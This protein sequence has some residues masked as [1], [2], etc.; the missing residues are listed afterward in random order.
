M[1][2]FDQIRIAAI[3]AHPDDE[4]FTTGGVLAAF[5]DRGS[6]VTLICAT[7]GEEGEISHPSLATPDNLGEVREQELRDAAAILG[8][9]DVRF[10]DYRD[11]G[12]HGTESNQA[13]EAFVRQP[14][15]QVV[16]KLADILREIR[17]DLVITFSEEGVYFHPD[18]IY[19]HQVVLELARRSPELVPELYFVSF[20]RE[21][22][23][24][25]ANQDHGAFS[26]MPAEQR[27]RLGQPRDSFT[28]VVDVHPYVDRKVDA[29]A[30]HKTQQAK[31]GDPELFEDQEQRRAFARYEHY[32]RVNPG[33]ESTDFLFALASDI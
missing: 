9:S 4:A 33:S 11:S 23:E 28:H 22:F 26:A 17:P 30:A 2:E 3:F 12:M 19:V 5:T 8:I 29:F 13:A 32:I 10:L 20:P 16:D 21:F 1:T 24:E 31:E 15:D 7:R 6:A 14:I 27:A 18:H 25:L